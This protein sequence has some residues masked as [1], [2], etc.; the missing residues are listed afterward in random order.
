[1][2]EW[3]KVLLAAEEC[4][5]HLEKSGTQQFDDKIQSITYGMEKI[6]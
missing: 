6:C 5:N 3:F 2:D 1:M 4:I